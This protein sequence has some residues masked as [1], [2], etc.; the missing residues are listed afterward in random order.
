MFKKEKCRK[1]SKKIE[2]K[3]SFCPYCGTPVNS[4]N[5]EKW[6]ML[7][8]NDI[9]SLTK[10]LKLPL[11]FN[12]IFNSLMKNLSKEFETQMKDVQPEKKTIKKDGISISISTFGNGAPKIKV[13]ELGKKSTTKKETEKFKQNMF[14]KEK[15]QEFVESP[16]EEPKTNIRR[17]SN[18]V[19]YELE[20]PDVSGIE[21]VSIIKLENSIEIKAIGKGKSYS[22]MIPI[23]LPIR[24]YD[25]SEGK[26]ILELGVKG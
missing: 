18:K 12:T 8:K 5:E 14:T 7:G 24:S 9:E 4:E 3:Y 11:G 23:N 26:L 20:M 19:I 21:N 25:L 13:S 1:C 10:E 15:A 17:L 6:G 2:E 22:K 16:R